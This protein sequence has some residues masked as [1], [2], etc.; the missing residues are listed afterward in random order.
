MSLDFNLDRE[1]QYC[2]QEIVAFDSKDK[3]MENRL[4]RALAILQEQGV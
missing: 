4:R 2:S 3:D 1:A